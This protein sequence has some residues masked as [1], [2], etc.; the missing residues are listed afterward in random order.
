MFAYMFLHLR[1]LSSP[2]FVEY[3]Q[4]VHRERS[5]PPRL[6][7]SRWTSGRRGR[8]SK[9]LHK[10]LHYNLDSLNHRHRDFAIHC[11][12]MDYQDNWLG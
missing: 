6:N 11:E 7:G 3:F 2:L 8:K 10:N 4:V 9:Y 12:K 1:R 5:F